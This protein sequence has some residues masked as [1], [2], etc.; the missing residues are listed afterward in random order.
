MRTRE[1]EICQEKGAL[2][3]E[4]VLAE[5]GKCIISE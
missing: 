2:K 1:R 5:K 4:K 3:D